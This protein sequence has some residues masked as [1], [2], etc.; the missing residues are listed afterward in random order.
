M[1]RFTIRQFQFGDVGDIKQLYEHVTGC[2]RSREQYLWQWHQSPSGSGDIW[3][4]HDSEDDHKL[5][6]NHGVMPIRFTRGNTNLLFGK[7]ENTMVLPEYREKILYPRF[8]L[9]FKRDYENRYDALFSTMGPSPAIR[10]R[11]AMGY[12]LPPLQPRRNACLL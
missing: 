3:L 1:S 9:K 7:I 4:I 6:G 10:V 2:T 11:K 12:D 5:I 8:E